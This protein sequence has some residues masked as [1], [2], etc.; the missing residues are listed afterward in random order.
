MEQHKVTVPRQVF[1]LFSLIMITVGAVDSIRNLPTAALFGSSLIFFFIFAA[2]L[3]LLPSALV[4]AELV[5]AWPE[6]G[7]IYVWVKNAFG[8][9]IGFFAI[10]L[11]WVENLIWFPTILSFIAGSIGYL[12][13][14]RLANNKIFLFAIIISSFWLVTLINLRGTRSSVRFSNFCT[15]AGLLAP[16]SIII[17][18]GAVWI[19]SG[20]HSAITLNLP[21]L[22]PDVRDPQIWLS[23][24][25]IMMSY[26]GLEITTVHA[27]EVHNPQRNFPRAL[28]G[29][30]FI[31]LFTLIGGSLAIAVV[32]PDTNIDLLAGIMQ[33]FDIFFKLYHL[34]WI[35]PIVALMLV[36]GCIGG[37]SSWSIAPA[38]G[39]FIAAHDGHLPRHCRRENAFGAPSNLLIYQAV[40]VSCIALVFWLIPSVSGSY[41]L[42]TA[43]AAQL[44]MLMYVIMFAS[45][46]WLRFKH[47]NQHRP[48]KIPGGKIGVICIAGVGIIA[49]LLTFCIGFIPPAGIYVGNLWRY[50]ALLGSILLITCLLPLLK[51]KAAEII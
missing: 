22:I 11:Q 6:S 46:I 23:L 4:A 39:L 33:T 7:G 38:R 1:G 10:W 43:L 42:L 9:R 13:A 17:G 30:I 24:T 8:K 50:E 45:A 26:C 40:I 3:F 48:F 29:S 35:L 51:K 14:P 47:P 18:L 41:W 32:L 37:V 20:Q 25:A 16:I 27:H 36:I 44:Y 5:S 19:F 49:A 12:I 2:L 15:I 21:A 31:L 28:F 34:E